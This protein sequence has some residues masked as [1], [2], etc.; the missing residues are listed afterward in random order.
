MSRVCLRRGRRH[1]LVWVATVL[2]GLWTVGEALEAF[3]CQ[4]PAAKHLPL[5]TTAPPTCRE[6]QDRFLPVK[7]ANLQLLRLRRRRSITARPPG[8]R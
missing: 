2:F 5:D 8:A 7:E 3:D 4:H 1:L 6:E